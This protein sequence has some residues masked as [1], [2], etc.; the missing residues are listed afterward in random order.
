MIPN[1]K[2]TSELLSQAQDR[3]LTLPEKLRLELHLLICE[4][5]RNFNRQLEFMRA[6]LRRYRDRD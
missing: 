3:S 5:C 2:H 1:C 4:R 6:A